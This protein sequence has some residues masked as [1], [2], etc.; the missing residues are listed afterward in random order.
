VQSSVGP[1][2]DWSNVWDCPNGYF[3]RGYNLR[4]S[5]YT[6][7]GDIL[8]VVDMQVHCMND[9]GSGVLLGGITGNTIGGFYQWFGC[10]W[11]SDFITGIRTQVQPAQG[12]GDDSAL[13]DIRVD[14]RDAQ[15]WHPLFK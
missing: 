6:E 9:K 5:G 13:N 3:I 12:N 1:W 15:Q 11:E 10:P 7:T 2:G 4:Q 14:C 8:A